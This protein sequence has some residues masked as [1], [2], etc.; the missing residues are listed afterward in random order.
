MKAV[1]LNVTAD[2]SAVDSLWAVY[3][4]SNNFL[5]TFTISLALGTDITPTTPGLTQLATANTKI[6]AGAIAL[7]YTIAATDIIWSGYCPFYPNE[8]GAIQ[9]AMPQAPIYS[10]PTF[11]SSTTATKLSAT[12]ESLVS[13]DFDAVLTISLLAGQSITATLKYADDSGMTT[14][15]VLVSSQ[16]ASISGLVGL[17]NT[18]TLKV[19]GPVPANKYR[20]VTFAVT[21][22]AAAPTIIKAG[23]EKVI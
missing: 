8:I 13:Y 7:G 23:T 5:T 14:N 4:N 1:F 2:I 6:I 3:D 21:G 17:S 12:R 9:A 15:V 16:Q 11:S 19:S 18:Q 20:Q 10:I 22:S